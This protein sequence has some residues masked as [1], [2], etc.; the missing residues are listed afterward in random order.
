MQNLKYLESVIDEDERFGVV[1]NNIAMK[2]TET[3]QMKIALTLLE[4]FNSGRFVDERDIE[5]VENIFYVSK[6]KYIK[7]KSIP[8]SKVFSIRVNLDDSEE[9]INQ[10]ISELQQKVERYR[11]S[12]G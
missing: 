1:L 4:F 7:Q 11:N 3:I 2:H 12:K 6:E 8:K 9:E 10:K 5:K